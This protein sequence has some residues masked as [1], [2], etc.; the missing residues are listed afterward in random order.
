MSLRV[1]L[2]RVEV[3]HLVD[4]AN[5]DGCAH[6][7]DQ[8]RP[9]LSQPLCLLWNVDMLLPGNA[10]M[11]LILNLDGTWKAALILSE[12]KPQ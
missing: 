8:V 3:Q 9:G 5:K 7:F 11:E 10:G 12:P 4:V 1:E 2:S 6:S